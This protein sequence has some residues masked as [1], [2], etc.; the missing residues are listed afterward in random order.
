MKRALMFLLGSVAACGGGE[1]GDD[2]VPECPKV[3][4]TVCTV[5]G[6]GDDGDGADNLPPLETMLALPCDVTFAPNGQMVIV[7]WNNHRIRMLQEDGTLKVVAGIGELGVGLSNDVVGDR[8]NHPTDVTFDPEGR[9]VIAAWH[10]SRVKRLDLAT[11]KLEDIAGNGKRSYSGDGGDALM[12]AL[13]LPASVLY[14]EKGILYIADQANQRIRTVDRNGI[15]NTYAGGGMK[16]YAGDGG[17]KEDAMFNLPVGQMGHPAAHIAR[18]KAGNIFLADTD[19]HRIR[20]IAADGTVST[21]VGTG[22][23]GV[24]GENVAGPQ[25]ALSAPVDVAIGPDGDLYFADT[26]N[27]CIRVL[28]DGKVSTAVGRCGECKENCDCLPTDG[29]CLGDGQTPDKTVLRRPYGIGF[30]PEGNLHVAD[31]GHSRIRVLYR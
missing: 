29:V 12:A 2:G 9:M 25:C 22:E 1:A 10:N 7:D 27:N 26:G 23:R 8:L 28:R 20:M 13:N 4:G 30:D 15:I 14:D 17:P 16:G 6:T 31:L 21:V 11:G 18:D 3:P 19:N 24:G 5:A